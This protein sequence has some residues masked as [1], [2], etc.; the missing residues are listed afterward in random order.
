M[1]YKDDT[2]DYT[3]IIHICTHTHGCYNMSGLPRGLSGFTM[4]VAGQAILPTA[5]ASKS[6]RKR[7]PQPPEFSDDAGAIMKASGLD[8]K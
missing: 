4:P 2:H 5:G 3:G 8:Q 6:I 7:K 1:I